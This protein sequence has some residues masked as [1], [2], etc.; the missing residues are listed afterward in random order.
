MSDRNFFMF[1]S[2]GIEPLFYGTGGGGELGMTKD[3]QLSVFQN[4]VMRIACMELRMNMTWKENG[5]SYT[6]KSATDSA[7]YIVFLE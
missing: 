2:K 6:K 4:C 5:E 7:L 3:Q 1:L